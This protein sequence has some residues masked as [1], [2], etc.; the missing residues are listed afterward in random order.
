MCM[1]HCHRRYKYIIHPNLHTYTHIHIR[2]ICINR[3]AMI[4]IIFD[5]DIL[6]I[7]INELIQN[8]DFCFVILV[9]FLLFFFLSNR[10]QSINSLK[11]TNI[12]IHKISIQRIILRVKME[13]K[14][15][16]IRQFQNS[17]VDMHAYIFIY[18]LTT[19]VP[20]INKNSRKYI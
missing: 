2:N 14:I 10:N 18:I 8:F 1:F 20:F 11:L 6:V 16:K 5:A 3:A 15:N 9:S 19:K 13:K 7:Q 12:S 17:N 4:Y